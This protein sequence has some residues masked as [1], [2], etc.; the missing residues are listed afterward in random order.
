MDLSH[1]REEPRIPDSCYIDPSARINGDVILGK[2]CSVWFNVSI[3]GDVHWIRVG[4]RTNIQDN[5]VLH[6]SYGA[7][8]LSIGN[9]VSLGHMVIAHGCTIFDRVLVGM[10]SVIMDGAIIGENTL[11]G[12]GSLVT[13]GKEI[14]PGVLA[15][16]RPAKVIRELGEEERQMVAN[17]SNEYAAYAEA[18]RRLGKFRTWKDNL[19]HKWL[20]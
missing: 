15:M 9:N 3:R 18:Y 13:E 11:I 14:P 6:T 12:A 16:G 20:G 10:Q 7:H 2:E 19:F 8:P 5:C 4:D 1:L 17:R